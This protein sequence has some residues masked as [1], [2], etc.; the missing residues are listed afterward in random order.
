MSTHSWHELEKQFRELEVSLQYLRLDIQLGDSGE[1]WRLAGG[2]D[3][4]IKQ[5]FEILVNIAGEKL[6]KS[7]V[8][9][10]YKDLSD[11]SD[12]TIRWYK[13]IQY[14]GGNSKFDLFAQTLDEKG[15]VNGHIYGGTIDKIVEES[16]LLCLRLQMSDQEVNENKTNSESSNNAVFNAPIYGGVQIGG[17]QNSQNVA[18]NTEIEKVVSELIGL[19]KNSALSDLDKED[20]IEAVSKVPDLTKREQSQDIIERIEKRLTTT[21]TIIQKSKDLALLAAPAIDFLQKL[22]I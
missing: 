5:R 4:L 18:K 7:K 14:I 9:Q 12:P 19:L 6:G 22:I 16:T 3:K 8:I 20:A 1:H 13:G 17:T 15:E 2:G 11:E 10:Q 21:A